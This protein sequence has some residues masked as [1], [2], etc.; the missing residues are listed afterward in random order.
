MKKLKSSNIVARSPLTGR[1]LDFSRR[2]EAGHSVPVRRTHAERNA[3]TRQKIIVATAECIDQK[4]FHQASLQQVAKTA[5]VTVGAV[6]HHFASKFDLLEAVVENCFQQLTQTVRQLDFSDS[7]DVEGRI[8]MFVGACWDFCSSSYYQSG[9]QILLGMRGEGIG[10]YESWLNRTLGDLVGEGFSL[11]QQVFEDVELSD[12]ECF[13]LLLFLFSSLSGIAMF[14]R[15]SQQQDR[16]ASDLREL[17]DLLLLKFN[18]V[19][20]RKRSGNGHNGRS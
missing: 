4:G 5:G 20:L 7:L 6:Q 11:W 9:I 14:H 1:T 10:D 18:S 16:L 19:G 8:E 17:K 2:K 3:Q 15:I 12:E 13:D